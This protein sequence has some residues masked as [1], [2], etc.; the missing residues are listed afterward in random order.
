MRLR[1]WGEVRTEDRTGN[2]TG[3]EKPKMKGKVETLSFPRES[4]VIDGVEDPRVSFEAMKD[5]L[6]AFAEGC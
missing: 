5:W 2:E 6:K 1:V 4:H 3:T